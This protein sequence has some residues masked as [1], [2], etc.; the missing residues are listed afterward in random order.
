VDLLETSSSQKAFLKSFEKAVEEDQTLLPKVPHL[1]K[2][3]TDHEI[4]E[5]ENMIA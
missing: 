1:L 5:E 3:F 2:S 4:V